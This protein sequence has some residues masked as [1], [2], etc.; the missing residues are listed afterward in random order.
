MK[1]KLFFVLFFAA[2]LCAQVG[3]AQ[4]YDPPRQQYPIPL[5]RVPS[6]AEEPMQRQW[7]AQQSELAQLNLAKTPEHAPSWMNYY[8]AERYKALSGKKN[9]LPPEQRT[10][11]SILEGMKRKARPSFEYNYLRYLNGNHDTQLISFLEK[12]EAMDPERA[13]LC[14]PF[15]AYYLLTGDKTKRDAWLKKWD[16]RT[17]PAP[18]LKQYAANV[19]RSLEP[20]AVLVTNGENDTYP[21]LLEQLS[22]NLRPDITVLPLHIA[23]NDVRGTQLLQA[24][25][26][27]VPQADWLLHPGDYWAG[28][29]KSNPQRPFYFAATTDTSYLTRLKENLFLTGLAFRYSETPVNNLPQLRKNVSEIF[30]LDYLENSATYDAQHAFNRTQVNRLHLN[31][32]LP[33]LLTAELERKEGKAEQAK[34]HEE[35]ALALARKGG[36]E[37]Q[38]KKY[39]EGKR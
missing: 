30:Q 26:L 39:L 14:A 31:Y 16:A 17:N 13:E 36:R 9:L 7:Y 15:I 34:K 28:V 5:P 35:L 11:D 22:K 32:V 27:N 2:L 21:L 10:L 37:A 29:A 23:F 12:A 1:C 33:L 20:N 4:A 24:S 38:V 25:G 8:L 18:S 6:P 3:R 19:L